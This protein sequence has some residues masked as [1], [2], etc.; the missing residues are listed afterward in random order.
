MKRADV[1][2]GVIYR[3]QHR[4]GT[5][6]AVVLSVS[7]Q[8][9]AGDQQGY[10]A[11]LACDNGGG[12]DPAR[13]DGITLAEFAVAEGEPDPLAP[14][15]LQRLY[16]NTT[17]MC[18]S[19]CDC[20]DAEREFAQVTA[21]QIRDGLEEF[22][23][24]V[25]KIV[26]AYERGHWR[27]LGYGS[28]D[29]YT[30]KEFGALMPR[31]SGE[32]VTELVTSL[33]GSGMS[34]RAIAPVAGVSRETVRKIIQGSADKELPAGGTVKGRDGRN[35]PAT[36]PR[37]RQRATADDWAPGLS[38]SQRMILCRIGWQLDHRVSSGPGGT[39]LRV[40]AATTFRALAARKLITVAGIYHNLTDAGRK[41]FA[42]APD[43]FIEEAM[44]GPD[45]MA[46]AL[47]YAAPET[48]QEPAETEA[49]PAATDEPTT[50]RE[51]V[52]EPPGTPEQVLTNKQRELL[53]GL[54]DAGPADWVTAGKLGS[55]HGISNIVNH[56]PGL[57]EKDGGGETG[58]TFR[59][60]LTD[61]GRR[62]CARLRP[63]E[64]DPV[65]LTDGEVRLM[66]RHYLHDVL[67]Y[68]QELSNYAQMLLGGNRSFDDPWPVMVARCWPTEPQEVHV[69]G[70]VVGTLVF[71][72][73]ASLPAEQP[74]DPPPAGTPDPAG[75]SEATD[76]PAASRTRNNVGDRR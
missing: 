69:S 51:P 1:E 2:V 45:A 67:T 25:D 31:L 61:E 26:L 49:A 37:A 18:L 68:N 43:A 54:Y 10:P 55:P 63:P 73:T 53:L 21:S 57:I 23:R 46:A 4:D 72:P 52:Q 48:A 22:G 65:P 76:A 9:G 66:L 32:Q 8:Y 59:V 33:R 44:G 29:D 5:G 42:V 50:L 34:T 3:W 70:E 24:T 12:I 16:L 38:E 11:V 75:F 27:M 13:L 6:L 35:H 36:K 74:E 7:E 56:L 58:L 40:G 39:I 28:W 62:E 19:A 71:T 64:P 20:A 14:R 47:K 41:V 17:V 30:A 60:R 15:R